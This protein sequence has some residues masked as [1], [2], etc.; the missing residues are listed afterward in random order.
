[1]L[2][3]NLLLLFYSAQSQSLDSFSDDAFV[4]RHSLIVSFSEERPQFSQMG[5][6]DYKSPG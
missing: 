3:C 5:P 2:C 1:M 6:N 4:V